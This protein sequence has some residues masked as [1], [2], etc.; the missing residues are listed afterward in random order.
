[1]TTLEAILASI[2]AEPDPATWHVLADWL[3]EHDDPRRAELTRLHQRLLATCCE[4]E[5]NPERAAWQRRVVALLGQGVQPCVPQEIVPLPKG[6]DMT[7]RFIPPGSFLMGS[8]PDEE[9]GGDYRMLHRVTLTRGFWLGDCPVTQGQRDVVSG[10]R[11]SRL[12]MIADRPVEA[13]S[14]DDCQEFCRRLGHRTG[15]R[16]RL[17]REAEWE[18]ACRSGTTTPFFFGD[19]I[20]PDQASYDANYTDDEDRWTD[21]YRK[22]TSP[23]GSFP[24]NAW[25]LFDM[26]GNVWEWCQDWYD[27]YPAEAATDPQGPSTGTARVLRGGSWSNAP[28]CCR[29][30]WRLGGE[31][32]CR[33]DRHGFRVCLCLD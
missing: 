1:M 30:D 20:S 26:H 16:F 10:V 33:R 4:P 22:Q 9:A 18:Y 29:S 13:V 11:P 31:P 17:P 28:T 27:H 21:F 15:W 2:V 6:M 14:W 23:V 5:K 25:G 19:T 3:E 8:P 32:G 24:P 7:Y 12:H